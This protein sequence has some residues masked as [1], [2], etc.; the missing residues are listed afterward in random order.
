[1]EYDSSEKAYK[2]TDSFRPVIFVPNA[3]HYLA[4]LRALA[5]GTLPEE[6]LN[7]SEIP[8]L[9]AMPIPHRRVDPQILRK[10][11]AT[12][13][14]KSGLSIFYH[15]M[16]EVRPKPLWREITPHAFAHD[17]LR[18]H[19]RGYCHLEDRFKDF[20][21]SRVLRVGKTVAPGVNASQDSDWQ[22]FFEV[23]LVPNPKLSP[24]QRETIALDYGMTRHQLRV[25]IRCALLYY[26]NKRLRLDVAE[27]ID[28]P[29]ETPI[30]IFNKKEFLAALHKAGG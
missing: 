28:N 26:F 18:W 14:E 6:E 2:A 30:I 21:L 13:R 27:K 22:R 10:I 15:S 16:N 19:L 11:V 1:M 25:R 5:D 8:D 4:G 9:D 12:I 20:V 29:K 23:V 24:S 7:L 3:D 17:G